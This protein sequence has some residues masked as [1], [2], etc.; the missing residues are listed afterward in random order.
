MSPG[1][2]S[3]LLPIHARSRSNF[4]T[5]KC[6]AAPL[7]LPGTLEGARRCLTLTPAS[8]SPPVDRASGVKAHLS[9]RGA[10]GSASLF[11]AT[12]G[13]ANSAN[14][15]VVIF[16]FCPLPMVAV[17]NRRELALSATSTKTRER[18]LGARPRPG[19]RLAR[20]QRSVRPVAPSR[21]LDA[22]SIR[23]QQ[24]PAYDHT[25]TMATQR[26]APPIVAPVLEP[27]L[28]TRHGEVLCPLASR[29]VMRL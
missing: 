21:M 4:G 3:M 19:A 15:I 11:A 7:Q 8:H 22:V 16:F 26:N 20:L 1:K 10:V 6:Q 23:H 17:V 28:D 24:T 18:G 13:P 29:S 9:S 12:S 5:G 27:L 25:K 2:G 14:D